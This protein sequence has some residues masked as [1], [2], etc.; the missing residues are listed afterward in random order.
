MLVI[1]F[2]VGVWATVG[3]WKRRGGMLKCRRVFIDDGA[4]KIEEGDWKEF[5][6]L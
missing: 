6:E 2:S 5:R 1:F 3:W 4:R